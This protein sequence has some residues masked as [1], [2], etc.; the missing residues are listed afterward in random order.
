MSKNLS[1]FEKIQ[2]SMPAMS[3]AKKAIAKYILENWQEVAFLSASRLARQVGVSESVVVRFSQD[4]GYTGFPDLQGNLQMILRNRMTGMFGQ[5]GEDAQLELLADKHSS[6]SVQRVFDLTIKNLQTTL[7]SNSFETFISAVNQITEARRIA[8][9]AGRNAMGPAL[10]LSIHL[11]EIFTNTQLIGSGQDDMFDHLRSL[12]EQ[13]LLIT[14]GLPGYSRN[15]VRAVAYAEERGIKQIAITDSLSSPLAR[16]N[17]V[18]LLTS[19]KSLAYASSHVSTVFLIDTLI[20][21]ITIKDK[22]QV[23]KSLEELAEI[24][25]QYGL[26]EIE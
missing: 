20:H 14:I 3:D 2:V 17:S 4:L 26:Y 12:T 10:T 16:P 22:G 1:L 24:N 11:N 7:H 21:L 25:K 13:D 23:L 8:I 6:G 15:T 18:V 19:F 5:N 9:I